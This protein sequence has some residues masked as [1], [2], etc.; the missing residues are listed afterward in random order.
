MAVL[1][2]RERLIAKFAILAGLRPG[3]IPGLGWGHISDSHVD[4]RQRMYRGQIDSP[5][6]TRSFRKAALAARLVTEIRAWKEISL[7]PGEDAWVSPSETG[8][9]PLSRDNVWRRRFGPKLKAA[10][11]GWVD[12]HVMRRT[13]PTLMNEIHDDPQIVADQL[14]HTVDLN[15]NVYPRASV[16]R[17][18]ESVDAPESS[19]PA[20]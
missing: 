4:I 2:Q 18:K 16:A 12:F 11:L 19:L 6:S 5:R 14:G 9:T 1:E 8:R 15:Q 17:R 20:M 7:T 10:G 13:H 3:E